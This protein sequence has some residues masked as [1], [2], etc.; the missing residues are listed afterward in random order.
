MVTYRLEIWRV[1][2]A[3]KKVLAK[4][5]VQT[6]FMAS[7]NSFFRLLLFAAIIRYLEV[8]IVAIRITASKMYIPE[9]PSKVGQSIISLLPPHH[10]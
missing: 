8:I 1:I 10:V 4:I 5:D 6:A 2:D 7:T 9:N 3:P